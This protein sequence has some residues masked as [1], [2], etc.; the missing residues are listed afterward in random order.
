MKD[1]HSATR[2]AKSG[3]FV[4]T[5]KRG[6]KIS[7]VEGL[8][9]SDRMGAVVR[10]AASGHFLSSDERRTLVKDTMRKK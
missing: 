5:S 6:E 10:Q 1:K 7:A 3:Q 9:L 2:S 8:K 4:L